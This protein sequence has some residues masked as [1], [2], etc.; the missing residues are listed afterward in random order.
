MSSC[1]GPNYL[2]FKMTKGQLSH[3][4]SGKFTSPSSIESSKNLSEVTLQIYH[5]NIHG[6]LCIIHEILNF[7]NPDFPHILCLTEHHLNQNSR[8]FI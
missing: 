7:L 5:Q 3:V 1:D 2:N 4:H 8:Q 6:L